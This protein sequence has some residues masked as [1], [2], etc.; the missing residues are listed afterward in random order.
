MSIT[1]PFLVR[2][3]VR[4]ETDAQVP[5]RRATAEVRANRTGVE[6]NAAIVYLIRVGPRTPGGNGDNQLARDP[7]VLGI[8][9]AAILAV[10]VH[11]M[12]EA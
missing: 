4:R 11:H 7:G 2:F 12:D 9:Q 8:V 5:A 1:L 6:F 3:R 10:A